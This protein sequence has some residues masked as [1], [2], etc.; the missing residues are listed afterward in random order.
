MIDGP[1]R[2][3][4]LTFDNGPDAEVTPQVLDCLATH[5]VK[6]TFFVIGEKVSFPQERAIAR[7]ASDAG[8]WIGN[9]TYTHTYPLGELDEK[10]AME[11]F[12][13]TEEALSW[14]EQPMRLFRPYGRGGKIGPHLLCPAVVKRLQS[15]AITCVLWNCL[16]GDW[17]DPSGWLTRA[18]ADCHSRARSLVVLHDLPT[19]AMNH[20]AEFI[21]RLREDGFE[22]TQEFPSDCVP[23]LDGNIKLPLDPYVTQAPQRAIVD[24]GGLP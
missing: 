21:K 12:E 13:R 7:R 8:H 5:A 14:L 11:E 10:S 3:V 23:I 18:L 16:P 6:A 19:G 2:K 20:L 1:A 24:T 22:L 15:D 9:H 4:T 17:R